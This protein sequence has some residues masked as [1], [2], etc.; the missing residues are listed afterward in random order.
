MLNKYFS[1]SESI[2]YDYDALKVKFTG[3]EVLAVFTE[4]G[5]ALHAAVKVRK[6]ISD[7]LN[8]LDIGVGIGLNEGSLM[9]GII[10]AENIRYYDVIGDT[11][12][13]GKRIEGNAG[14]NEILISDSVFDSIQSEKFCFGKKREILVKGKVEPL[15]VYPVL[16]KHVHD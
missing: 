11:V 8:P 4:A 10:G 2:L 15:S 7:L 14:S 5:S 13:T 3:D 16:S 1:I 9:E 6:K 12:N